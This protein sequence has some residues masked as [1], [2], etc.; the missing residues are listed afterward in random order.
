MKNILKFSLFVA[1]SL[2]ITSCSS[3]QNMLD[4]KK[5]S[6][7]EI[8][9]SL[10]N[11]SWILKRI[12]ATNRDFKPTNEQK[13]LV[14]SFND[15]HYSSSDGCNGQGGTFKVEESKI[16]FGI[17]MS[18]LRY[19]GEEMNHLIYKV[20]FVKSKSITIHKDVL[21]LIDENDNVV[22]TYTKKSNK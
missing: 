8:E 17:G 14:L 5:A 4:T 15:G 21:K 20:P 10:N 11:T 9:K 19:C 22:A 13:E 7:K 6:A 3:S 18:T 1:L 16:T 2:G 12:D